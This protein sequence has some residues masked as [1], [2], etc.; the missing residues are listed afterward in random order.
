MRSDNGAR[1]REGARGRGRHREC[2]AD[3]SGEEGHDNGC[4]GENDYGLSVTA[5]VGY[6]GERDYTSVGYGLS[7]TSYP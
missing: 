3:D 2:D 7:F 5:W 1:S 4:V 6:G